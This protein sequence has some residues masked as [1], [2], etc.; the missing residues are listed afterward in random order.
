MRKIKLFSWFLLSLLISSTT[1]AQL[2]QSVLNLLGTD[3]V[4]KVQLPATTIASGEMAKM[5]KALEEARANEM[6]LRMEMEQLHAKMYASDSLEKAR[7]RERID[8]LRKITAKIPV[9]VDRDTLYYLYAK[10]GGRSPRDR[11]KNVSNAVL[12]LGKTYMLETDS[13]YCESTDIVTDIVYKGKVIASFTDQDG[14]W[15]NT[16]REELAAKN[17]DII[18]KKL[19]K[20]HE[21]YDLLQLGKRILLL[22]L[23]IVIQGALF[24]GTGWIYRRLRNR[25]EKQKE[26]K[27]KPISFHDYELLNTER[28]VGLLVLSC[29][30]LR[31][32][33]IVIQL[34]ISVPILFSI[35]P[36][37]EDLAYRIF[38]YIWTP[39]KDIFK[40]IIDYLPN[41]FTIIV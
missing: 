2:K 34:F 18:V 41:L 31:L 4:T 17:R 20:L 5:E 38:S 32:V 33:L 6:S 3:T 39:V 28:Q 27:L 29:K 12:Q 36:Q 9:V 21:A 8:S 14:L 15:E 1:H 40:G 13:V 22:I 24:W 7:Q 23:V 30:A 35:F 26:T 37:T 16:T 25:V 10:H 19:Q 11:A